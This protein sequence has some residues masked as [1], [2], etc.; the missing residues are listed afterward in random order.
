MSFL[1]NKNQRVFV[2]VQYISVDFSGFL[3]FQ[4]CG[5]QKVLVFTK[6]FNLNCVIQGFLV[7]IASNTLQLKYQLRKAKKKKKEKS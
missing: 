6:C 3:H 4:I 7:C 5:R 2:R 1:Q